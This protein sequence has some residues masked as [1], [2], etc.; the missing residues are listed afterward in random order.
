MD[1]DLTPS[2]V[3]RSS[4]F[5]SRIMLVL[6]IGS[7][8]H[9]SGC[10][11]E[12]DCDTIVMLRGATTRQPLEPITVDVVVPLDI[13][14]D[15]G[16]VYFIESDRFDSPQALE[17]WLRRYRGTLAEPDRTMVL[18]K[19]SPDVW[20]QWVTRGI[21]S[22][23]AAGFKH[24]GLG[25]N[26]LSV[27][28]LPRTEFNMAI[29]ST[30]AVVLSETGHDEDVSSQHGLRHVPDVWVVNRERVPL[31][32]ADCTQR[33]EDL[34]I[35]QRGS[36]VSGA[37]IYIAQ[38]PRT[39]YDDVSPLLD[40][41]EPFVGPWLAVQA[42]GGT[43]GPRGPRLPTPKPPPSI[44]VELP[45]GRGY[46]SDPGEVFGYTCCLP[47]GM[48]HDDVGVSF[49]DTEVDK[50]AKH[51]VFITDRTGS[52]VTTFDYVRLQILLSISQL[53][54]TRQFHIVLFGNVKPVEAPARRLVPATAENKIAAVEF[55]QSD[56]IRPTGRTVALPALRRAFEVLKSAGDE[57]DKVILLLTDG[58]FS[59]I[60]GAGK[61]KGKSGNEAVVSFLKDVNAKGNV[62]IHT[63]LFGKE[64]RATETMKA[65]A[66]QHGGE[67]KA[68]DLD[69]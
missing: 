62:T 30:S 35:E 48:F 34:L 4:G 52:M 8:V 9:A 49:F 59:G 31:V 24:V 28:T 36:G 19:P 68:I 69:E 21:D 67:F 26:L 55:L 43:G 53:D 39:R 51:F 1:I 14:D 13:V 20:W 27:E 2:V 6:L 32:Q 37:P 47:P 29:F 10:G 42:P 41:A 40:A 18:L 61:Y 56:Q 5:A 16:G 7:C 23:A 15:G 50:G 63:F 3:S 60:D 25:R 64:E 12:S 45:H 11:E 44:H 65:I 17:T 66:D 46:S 54:P 58:G 22:A 57:K 38:N 33:L